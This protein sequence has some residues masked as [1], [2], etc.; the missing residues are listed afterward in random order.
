MCSVIIF[1]F[2]GILQINLWK[3]KNILNIQ[4]IQVKYGYA[5]RCVFQEGFFPFLKMFHSSIRATL[6]ATK[7]FLFVKNLPSTIPPTLS[8]GDS[9]QSQQP[10]L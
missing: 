5:K 10:P 3:S 6:A 2:S 4:H 8:G 1:V 7:L 9:C